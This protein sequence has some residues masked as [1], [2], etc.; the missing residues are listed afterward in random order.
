MERKERWLRPCKV[1]H[2]R[3]HRIALNCTASRAVAGT[4]KTAVEGRIG[5]RVVG[6]SSPQQERRKRRR[7]RPST[8]GNVALASSFGGE[9]IVACE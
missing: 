6:S 5:S 2:K 1:Q 7:Q 9:Q 8:R 3:N 4:G